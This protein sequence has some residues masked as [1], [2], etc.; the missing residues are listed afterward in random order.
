MRQ[1]PLGIDESLGSAASHCTQAGT[2]P[3]AAPDLQQAQSLGPH[4]LY[5]PGKRWIGIARP[6]NGFLALGW[7]VCPNP[8]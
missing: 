1:G 4:L 5:A 7:S 6:S 8:L 2:D 3:E